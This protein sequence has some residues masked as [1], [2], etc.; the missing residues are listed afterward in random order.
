MNSYDSGYLLPPT[1]G[2][3]IR[4]GPAVAA[5]QR[6]LQRREVD[7]APVRVAGRLLIKEVTRCR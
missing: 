3:K 5:R 4:Y 2:P 7:H 6:L 1:F